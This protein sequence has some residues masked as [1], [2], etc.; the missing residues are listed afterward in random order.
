MPSVFMMVVVKLN[1]DMVS[2][3]MLSVVMLSV[4]MLSVIMLNCRNAACH[5]HDCCSMSNYDG[6]VAVI[7]IFKASKY[8]LQ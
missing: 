3:V 2:V 1:V 6:L 7:V 8:S 5:Y 4:V